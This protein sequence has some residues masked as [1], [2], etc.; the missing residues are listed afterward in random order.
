MSR[1]RG[2]KVTHRSGERQ[3]QVGAKVEE[4]A[5]LL[6]RPQSRPAPR[7]DPARCAPADR[8]ALAKRRA[9]MLAI[10]AVGMGVLPTERLGSWLVQ[11]AEDGR[12]NLDG[13]S[14]AQRYTAVM[15]VLAGG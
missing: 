9:E 3:S 14:L 2:V 12:P 10:A 15:E 6:S 1:G 4:G 11:W 5:S 13:C 7:P 8:E